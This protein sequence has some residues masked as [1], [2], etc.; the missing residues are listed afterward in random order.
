MNAPEIVLSINE[1]L[2]YFTRAAV[3]V[4]VPYGL[5]QDFARSSVWIGFSGLDP[6]KVSLPALQSIDSGKSI[7]RADQSDKIEETVLFPL[8][9]AQLSSLLGG[10][11]VCDCI[12]LQNVNSI[13]TRIVVKNIDHPF[14]IVAAL[15][16]YN[17]VSCEVSWE[18][19]DGNFCEVIINQNGK[20]K[21][22]WS[23]KK[24]PSQETPSDVFVVLVN[25]NFL[26]SDKWEKKSTYYVNK[27]EKVLEKGVPIYG[28]W[29]EIY[30]YFTRILVPSTHN[31]R[32]SGAGAGLVDID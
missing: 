28:D 24:I 22:S 20:W 25:D 7:L 12:A 14:L 29:S 3:G 21:A 23:D 8:E 9:D 26:H 17:F 16:S 4:G 5:A 11:A 15:A 1:I 32:I 10:P 31:S 19:S 27:R 2:F 30:S 13:S 6:A 18:D